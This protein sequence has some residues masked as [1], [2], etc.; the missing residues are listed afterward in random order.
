[1]G[2]KTRER[3]QEEYRRIVNVYDICFGMFCVFMSG[4]A[5]FYAFRGEVSWLTF[6]LITNF[7][8]V[9]LVL[10]QISLR[11]KDAFGIEIFRIF[12]AN[13]PSAALAFWY[14]DGPLI[15]F[16]P[17]YII[18]CMAGG[19][20]LAS[21]TQRRL[22]GYV[23]M[24]FWVANFALANWFKS[25]P[26]DWGRFIM[27]AALIVMMTSLF[28]ELVRTLHKSIDKENEIK[29]QLMQASKLTALGEMAGGVAH[30]I[31]TPLSIISMRTEQLEECVR[32]SAYDEKVFAETLSVIKKTTDRI[33][34]IVSGLRFFARDGRRTK[35]Q[36]VP[37]SRLVEDT[38]SLC[39]ERFS[40]HG[41]QLE[42]VT[43]DSYPSLSME[44][45]E[46]EVSQVLLN[47]LNNAFDAVMDSKE[48]WVHFTVRDIG[49]HIEFSIIDSGAGISPH[50]QEK[51]MQPFFTTKS[52]GKGT[53]LGLSISRGIVESHDGK[54]FFDNTSKNTKFVV[55]LPKV[56]QKEVYR[57]S[58]EKEAA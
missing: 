46:V 11:A 13:G 52:V 53:G 58:Y 5:L 54:L 28:I 44:C 7:L 20:F 35:P 19:V 8:V 9:N 41:V 1:M 38:L 51:M 36:T 18:M 2:Q 30:E 50:V 40:N 22:W 33:A 23:Q 6:A 42:L 25:N 3:I 12:F 16:S 24:A 15:N 32:E 26:L 17:P 48:K 55:R 10:S 31:N 21:W 47:L 37:V 34:K 4:L 45:R 39:R 29:A 49:P 56:Q 43:E 57:N 14:S 27:V